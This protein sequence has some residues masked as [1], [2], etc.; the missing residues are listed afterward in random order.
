M[1]GFNYRPKISAEMQKRLS[2]I[3]RHDRYHSHAI[4]KVDPNG[5]TIG[6]TAAPESFEGRVK[7]DLNRNHVNQYRHSRIGYNAQREQSKSEPSA[8]S[9]QSELRRPDAR[10]R[11][12]QPTKPNVSDRPNPSFQEPR[13][14][15]YNPY[16]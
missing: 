7:K 2:S 9:S 1:S 4:A 15:N 10:Q 16:A 3:D 5:Q 6:S 12:N 13:G 14:R 11:F 8:N